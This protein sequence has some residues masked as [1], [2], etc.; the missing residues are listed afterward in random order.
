MKIAL[1]YDHVNKIGGA[2][3]IV[4][5]LHELYPEAPIYTAVYNPQTAPW[6]KKY[7]VVTSFMQKLPWAKLYHELY[8]ILPTFA[9]ESFNFNSFDLVISVTSAEAKSIITSPRTVHICYCLTPTRYLWSHSRDYFRNPLFKMISMPFISLLRTQDF[10]SS[11]R[12][13]CFI[14]ISETVKARIKKYYGQSSQV[15]YPPV[16]T[17]NF[18]PQKKPRRGSYFLIVSRLVQYKKI[19]LAIE[20]FNELKLSLKIVGQGLAQKELKQMGGPTIEF[21]EHLT[22]DKLRRYYQ[23]CRAFIFP[24]EEDFGIAALE[25]M[26][27]GKPVLAFKSGG[28]L[29]LIKQG[30]TGEFFFPQTKAALIRGIKTVIQK[31]YSPEKCRRQAEKFSKKNFQLTFKQF[32]NLNSE[33]RRT[34]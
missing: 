6:A 20:A 24:Q 5:S 8:P 9:F 17:E 15:I 22:D 21:L 27:C 10:I 2:E 7:T 13:D 14:A 23:N 11:R 34:Y 16:D 4:E 30:E 1:V 29:E 28:A 18:Y 19:N 25:A 12:P 31:D 33:K 26:A 3:R 32:I